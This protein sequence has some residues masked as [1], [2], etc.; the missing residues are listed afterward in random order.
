VIDCPTFHT[1][2][3]PG[4][5]VGTSYALNMNARILE[6]LA[7]GLGWA[8]ATAM[9]Q[10]MNWVGDLRNRFN[11]DKFHLIGKNVASFD[12]QFLK[13][14]HGWNKNY[15]SHRH[16]DVGSLYSTP[17]GIASQDELAEHLIAEAGIEGC[18]HEALFDA[19]VSL[20]LAR[21]AWRDML[22]PPY[23]AQG[24]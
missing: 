10:L 23:G 22:E 16:L 20:E 19:R 6:H 5:I 18:P 21:R 13:R 15:F 12:L 24:L 3:N 14:V 7:S 2:V 1:I 17:A 8:P 9:V 4:E 11:I